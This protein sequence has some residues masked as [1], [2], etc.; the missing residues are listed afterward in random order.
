MMLDTI[1]LVSTG[2]Q[3]LKL[4]APCSHVWKNQFDCLAIV[5]ER[6]VSEWMCANGFEDRQME[7]HS[8][9]E[10]AESI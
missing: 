9:P 1:C 6:I 5:G 4:A 7:R 3:L 2:L 8:Q 10:I